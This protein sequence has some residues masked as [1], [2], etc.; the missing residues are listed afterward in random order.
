MNPFKSYSL[1]WWQIGILKVAL[2]AFGV[3][4]GTLWPT[5]FRGILVPLVVLAILASAYIMYL[6][7]KQR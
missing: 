4:I 6:S 2:L 7:V 5:L 3:A 1:T